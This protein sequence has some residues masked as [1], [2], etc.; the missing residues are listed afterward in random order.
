MLAHITCND[1]GT[2]KVKTVVGEAII[3][4]SEHIVGIALGWGMS[5][6]IDTQIKIKFVADTN[7]VEEIMPDTQD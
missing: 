2:F 7:I 3:S 4:V 6:G 5:L 1:K